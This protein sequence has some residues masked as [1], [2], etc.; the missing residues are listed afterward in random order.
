VDCLACVERSKC[1]QAKTEPRELTFRPREQWIALQAARQ[2][3][4][5]AEF[6][7]QYAARAGSESTIS[8]ATRGFDL[9]RARYV[10]LAKTGL[11][12]IRIAVAI[13]L[14]R[15]LAWLQDTPSGRSPVSRFAALAGT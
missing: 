13:N 4:L 12:H 1:T 9:R 3:Q 5:T 15:F 2:R 10:G 6:R 14:T 11:Q 7:T 8:Q